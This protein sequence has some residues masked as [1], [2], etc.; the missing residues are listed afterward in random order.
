MQYW[1]FK[2]LVFIDRLNVE[3]H[4]ILQTALR[5]HNLL[6]TGQGGSG[7]SFLVKCI[8]SQLRSQGRNVTVISASGI[9]FHCVRLPRGIHSAFL[10]RAGQWLKLYGYIVHVHSASMRT[11]AIHKHI[12]TLVMGTPN[13]CDNPLSI[14]KPS[15]CFNHWQWIF[16]ILAYLPTRGIWVRCASLQISP[17][18]ISTHHLPLSSR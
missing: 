7:K 5:G 14:E 12:I 3:Q 6:I 1:V 10:I 11:D 4:R 9:S 17:F 16:S 2:Y 18:K 8:E 15:F 13:F